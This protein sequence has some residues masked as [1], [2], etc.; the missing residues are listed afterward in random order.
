MRAAEAANE[1]TILCM[2]VSFSSGFEHRA[3]SLRTSS[4]RRE[5]FDPSRTETRR[6]GGENVVSL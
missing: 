5:I 2:I 6:L 1:T 3:A 4:A